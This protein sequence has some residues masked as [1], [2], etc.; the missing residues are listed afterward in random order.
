MA[1][2]LKNFV[3]IN[4]SK[5]T[6]Y[7]SDSTRETTLL[8]TEETA[9]G[10]SVV[11]VDSLASAYTNFPKTTM[12]MTQAYARTYFE[13][14]GKSLKVVKNTAITSLTSD[15]IDQHAG[16]DI[17][18]VCYTAKTATYVSVYAKLKDIAITRATDSSIYGINEKIIIACTM[19]S[20]DE[21]ATKN[22]VAKYNKT[23]KIGSEMTIAAYL[24]QI[25]VY[26]T[27]SV[28]DYMFTQSLVYDSTGQRD[29][30]GDDFSNAEYETLINRNYNVDIYLANALRACGGNCKDGESIVN[31]FVRIV[32]HQ[33][34]TDRLMNLLVTKPK[35]SDG[36]GRIY[37]TIS[38][39]LQM[40]LN[41]GY[42]T[43]D[44]IWEYDDYIVT[45]N[46]V[47][48][49]IIE[50]NTPLINGYY[51]KVLPFSSLTDEEKTRKQA[52]Y[53]YVIIADQY[54]IRKIM[55]NGEVI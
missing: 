40:Y 23:E 53:I 29:V 36:I 6:L 44:K 43:T 49:T 15:L 17:I 30:Y 5:R 24:S 18:C 11:T 28:E 32:L 51:V 8:F 46:G 31:N 42:L 35:N 37:S 16:N 4:I 25:D 19:S 14:G 1:V 27:N 20:T 7:V 45:K 33:T 2:N 47:Q 39:E 9:A 13:N 3:D 52:P 54:G 41:S 12:P 21:D 10:E 48:Y 38:Q 26:K 55:I 34:L 22:F 50:K